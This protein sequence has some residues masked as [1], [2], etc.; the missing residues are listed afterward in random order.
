MVTG[1]KALLDH[2][3]GIKCSECKWESSKDCFP[4]MET[5]T[6]VSPLS[7]SRLV[8]R[9]SFAKQKHQWLGFLQS[10]C[11]LCFTKDVGVSLC[12]SLFV[13]LLVQASW[14]SLRTEFAALNPAQL[15]HMLREYNSGKTCPSGWTPS[16]D[17]AQDALRTGEEELTPVM[18]T[19]QNVK[20]KQQ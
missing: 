10:R 16:P 11:I 2:I 15:H 20:E 7:F 3:I 9:G 19:K 4:Y 1:T 6:L 18:K 5:N 17:D 12:F 13:P 14:T 8:L